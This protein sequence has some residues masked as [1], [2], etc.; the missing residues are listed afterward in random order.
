MAE[1]F[2]LAAGIL[3]VVDFGRQ[4]VFTARQ[5]YQS[6]TEGVDGLL[7][8][9]AIA[10]NLKTVLETLLAN[11]QDNIETLG[12]V[13]DIS[14][15]KECA[16]TLSEMLNTLEKIQ[17]P[18]KGRKRDATVAAFKFLWNKGKIDALQDRLDKYSKQLILNLT[19][20]LRWVQEALAT[21]ISGLKSL[22][23]CMQ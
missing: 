16:E 13:D 2:S 8:L 7:D 20:S 18:G 17:V 6:G 4:F 9:Q 1:A 23:E 19:F 15:T 5:F 21:S 10:I 22:T 14:L 11:A 3:Q 12:G